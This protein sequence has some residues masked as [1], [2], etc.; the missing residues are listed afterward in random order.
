M[1][2][3]QPSL[4]SNDFEGSTTIPEGSTEIKN[5]GKRPVYLNKRYVIYM[6][7]NNYR[8]YGYNIS[9]LAISKLGTNFKKFLIYLNVKI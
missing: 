4:I 3:Q 7:L 1:D 2:N 9:K 6:I 5:L 8:K